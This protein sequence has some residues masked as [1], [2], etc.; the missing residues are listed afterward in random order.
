MMLHLLFLLDHGRFQKELTNA[1]KVGKKEDEAVQM[2][3]QFATDVIG[4]KLE[5]IL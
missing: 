4:G 2:A 5:V 1:C 3:L